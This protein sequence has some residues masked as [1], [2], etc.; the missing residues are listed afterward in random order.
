MIHK[1]QI[2]DHM[3]HAKIVS[4]PEDVQN[5]MMHSH[6]DRNFNAMFFVLRNNE[7]QNFWMK[8]C[9]IPLDMI[10][11]DNNMKITTIQHSC[12]PCNNQL[13]ES[14]AQAPD[15]ARNHAQAPD[16]G[17]N[18]ICPSYSGF[19]NFVI[20]VEGGTCKKLNIL[21]NQE[22]KVLNY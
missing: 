13:N 8:N 7:M 18:Y 1:I 20:E 17:C 2:G 4:A 9:I 19:G 10:F 6:F 14:L 15:S 3:F 16:F 21:K 12:M 22:I 5:G 11:I